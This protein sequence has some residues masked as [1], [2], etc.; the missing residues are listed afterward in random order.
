ML[1][2]A[3]TDGE[4]PQT[5]QIPWSKCLYDVSEEDAVSVHEKGLCKIARKRLNW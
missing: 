3:V 5:N 2:L 4:T 1:L